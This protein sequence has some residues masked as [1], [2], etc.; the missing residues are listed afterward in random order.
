MPVRPISEIAAAVP[1]DGYG[2]HVG[3]LWL[4]VPLAHII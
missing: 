1:G 4:L 2:P 3:Q